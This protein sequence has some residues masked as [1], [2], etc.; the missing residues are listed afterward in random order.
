M[1]EGIRRLHSRNC[2]S[3]RGQRCDCGAG[4]EASVYSSLDRKKIRKSFPTLA[5][6]RAWRSEAATAVNRRAMRAPGSTTLREA[7]ATFIEGMRTGAVRTRS[8]DVY[9]PSVVRSY[10][11]SLERRVLPELGA[12]R[13]SDIGRRDVQRLAD[14]LLAAGA[15][16]ST[17]RG[18]LMPLRVIFRRALEDGDVTVNPCTGLRLPAVRG[19]RDRIVSA[20]EAAALIDAL[21]RLRDRALWATAFYAGL[22]LGELRGLRWQDIDF[23]AGSLRVERAIDQGS[24]RGV[25]EPK[26]RAGRRV[27]PMVGRLR[28]H[29]QALQDECPS[30]PASYV[31]GD[32]RQ[33]FVSSTAYERA[34]VAWR[35]AGLTGITLHEARHTCASIFIAAGVNPKPLSELMG[36]ASITITLDRYGH[37]MPGAR[38]E[39]RGLV[40]A[41]LDRA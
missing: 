37:L 9:K 21:P 20:E 11:S 5:A 15:D 30:H 38:D 16:P 13:V 12:R 19:R 40:D 8:G 4:W 3:K 10:S 24:N 7:A 39:V 41:Y 1:P 31:F 2:S 34:R 36:H 18:A 35:N 27:V 6:A 17:V 33:P 25:I 26:S 32:P 23:A 29:L 22:R 14:Q 28:G